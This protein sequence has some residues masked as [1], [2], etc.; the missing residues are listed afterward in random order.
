MKHVILTHPFRNPPNLLDWQGKLI[1]PDRV[2]YQY[3]EMPHIINADNVKVMLNN[4]WSP[5][6]STQAGTPFGRFRFIGFGNPNGSTALLIEIF[7][8]NGD[9]EAAANQESADPP[10][11]IFFV[12][13]HSPFSSIH[14]NRATLV[15]RYQAHPLRQEIRICRLDVGQSGF[16]AADRRAIFGQ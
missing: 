2:V 4:V 1:A 8:N 15:Y 9:S 16:G 12:H 14:A 13:E 3:E 7:N 10:N 5:V 6:H 11:G